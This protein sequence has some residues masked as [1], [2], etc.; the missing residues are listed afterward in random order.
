MKEAFYIFDLTNVLF[1]LLFLCSD[2]KYI[3]Y[4]QIKIV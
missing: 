4:K 2:A 3:I 1:F